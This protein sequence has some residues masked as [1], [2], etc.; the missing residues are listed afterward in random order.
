MLNAYG[1]LYPHEFA[2]YFEP[3]LGG[4][5]VFFDLHNKGRI[6]KATLSDSNA[7]LINCYVVIRDNLHQLVTKLEALQKL[8]MDENFYYKVARSRFNSIRL[9]DPEEGNLEKAALLIYLNKTCY[10]G[11]YRVNKK[12]EFNVPWGKYRN[13]HLMD[14]TNLIEISHILNEDGVSLRWSDY[15]DI[16]SRIKADDFVYFD[17]PYHPTSSTASFTA[18][19]PGDFG[20]E[21]QKKLAESFDSLDRKGAMLMLSNSPKASQYYEDKGYTIHRLKAVRAIS[22]IGSKRG[23]VEEIL[24]TNY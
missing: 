8:S 12:G 23:P 10:N 20:L 6:S 16:A 7:D 13:P 19:T 1:R 24:V 11:L 22:S 4:A 18:Y 2:S 15:K 17:P 14:K 9:K 21:E 3:F 5:A